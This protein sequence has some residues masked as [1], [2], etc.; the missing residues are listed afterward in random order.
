MDIQ[1]DPV[2]MNLPRT[3]DKDG[4][5]KWD[6]SGC[7]DPLVPVEKKMKVEKPPK[8]PS[9]SSRGSKSHRGSAAQASPTATLDLLEGTGPVYTET[10]D[11]YL[12]LPPP[13]GFGQPSAPPEK[14]VIPGLYLVPKGTPEDEIVAKG[15]PL[16][17]LP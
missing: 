5:P 1:H 17:Q 13:I 7:F 6:L 9:A 15:I 3:F 8:L 14:G 11:G 10:F 16:E 4:K 12:N 2:Q